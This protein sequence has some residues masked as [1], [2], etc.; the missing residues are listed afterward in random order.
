[1]STEQMVLR[2]HL[3][4]NTSVLKKIIED[5][6]GKVTKKDILE[7]CPDIS[8]TT[9]QRTL[10]DLLKIHKIIK[11]SGGRYTSYTWKRED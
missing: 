7:K 4:E 10:A 9:M 1:M 8:E 3:C 11:I 6:L 5:T 2:N